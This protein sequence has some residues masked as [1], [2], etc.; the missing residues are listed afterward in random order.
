MKKACFVFI[1]ILNII[2]CQA[3]S[4]AHDFY[5]T[6]AYEINDTSNSKMEYTITATTFTALF[7]DNSPFTPRRTV[8]E[9]FSWEKINND[10][11]GSKNDFPIGFIFGLRSAS[12]NEMIRLFINRDKK[13][14][15]SIDS[16]KEIYI[17]QTSENNP[18]IGFGKVKWGESSDGV[19]KAYK[20]NKKDLI[21]GRNGLSLIST[22]K[23]SSDY[24]IQSY[25]FTFFDDKLMTVNVEYYENIDLEYVLNSLRENYGSES[26][27]DTYFEFN[28]FL[29]SLAIAVF[30]K[31][32]KKRNITT[33]YTWKE[34]S[35][36]W[37]E[38]YIKGQNTK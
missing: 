38:R 26:P 13:S 2:S 28:K 37:V 33:M 5:G 25:L 9:I 6:W 23:N 14:L 12:K 32:E 34:Y 31:D 18:L 16:E 8:Y 7:T 21:L 35:E 24:S 19:I 15:M 20:L 17:K 30:P 36:I 27:I 22:T 1:T 4:P 10:D 11:G 29:P 3:N